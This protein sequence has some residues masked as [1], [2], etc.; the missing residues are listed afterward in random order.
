MNHVGFGYSSRQG[1]KNAKFEVI[2]SFAA[3]ARDIPAF[4]C[5]FAALGSLRL[6]LFLGCG[7]AAL[8]P[9]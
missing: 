2:S 8:S 6:N 5:G 1:A 9:L 3:F 7:V 4:G